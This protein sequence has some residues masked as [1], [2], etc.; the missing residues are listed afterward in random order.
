MAVQDYELLRMAEK[1]LAPKV[2]QEVSR[3]AMG[4]ILRVGFFGPV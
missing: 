1:T 4:R 3:L 2:F